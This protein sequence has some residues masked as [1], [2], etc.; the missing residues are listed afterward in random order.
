MTVNIS[1]D[2]QKDNNYVTLQIKEEQL[3]LAKKWLQTGDVKIYR[4]T[5]IEEKCFTVPVER[6]ELVIEK[7]IHVPTTSA[8]NDSPAEVIRI[9]LS[10]EQVKFTKH[11]VPLEDVSIYK[12]QIED[13]LHIEETLKREEFLTSGP[14][15]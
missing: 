5:L 1:S 9:S 7:T 8:Q 11:W 14:H 4:E 12:Q 13:I 3:I 2:S 6:Q 15:H 10:E